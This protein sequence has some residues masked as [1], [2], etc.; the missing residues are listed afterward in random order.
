[1]TLTLA[2]AGESHGPALVAIVTGLPAGLELDRD[3]IDADLRAAPGRAT[4]AARASR[5]RPTRSRC[6]PACATAARSARRSRSSSATA[7]TRTGR[8][9]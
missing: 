4:A 6:S 9:G 8:G 2:T 3:A 7:T 1:M 5:S